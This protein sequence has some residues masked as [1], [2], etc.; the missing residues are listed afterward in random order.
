MQDEFDVIVNRRKQ[1]VSP[2]TANDEDEF[3][4]I[5]QRRAPTPAERPPLW[6]RIKDVG[7]GIAAD[8]IGAAKGIGKGLAT[9]ALDLVHLSQGD[10][11]YMTQEIANEF[12]KGPGAEGRLIARGVGAASMLVPTMRVGGVV[13]SA[14]VNMAAN[15]GLGA[16]QTPED[17]MLGAILGAGVPLAGKAVGRVTGATA[18]A[19]LGKFRP[20]INLEGVTD[21]IAR[22]LDDAQRNTIP[23]RRVSKT[24]RAT[25]S[26]DDIGGVESVNKILAERTPRQLEGLDAA[27]VQPRP[28]PLVPAA[29]TPISGT[30]LAEL[31]GPRREVVA[32][33]TGK[34]ALVD[35]E[36]RADRV[37]G[38]RLDAAEQRALEK[39]MVKEVKEIDKANAETAVGML[40]RANAEFNKSTRAKNA[41]R[42]ALA[43]R[44]GVQVEP[45]AVD[46]PVT[47]AI[48]QSV[49]EPTPVA[50]VAAQGILEPLATPVA[51]PVGVV[52]PPPVAPSASSLPAADA[53]YLNWRTLGVDP[54]KPDALNM[55]AAARVQAAATRP[56][57]VER[58][59]KERGRTT[60]DAMNAEAQQSWAIRQLGID[61][62]AVD[63]EKLRGLSGAQ[64]HALK[65][66]LMENAA[67]MESIARELPDLSGDDLAKAT[68]V[69][70]RLE[71]SNDELLATI[72]REGS[73]RGRDLGALRQLA[74][75][76][77]D[78]AVWLLK[79]KKVLGDTPM[80]ASVQAKI[81]RL[82]KEA[83]EACGG[84]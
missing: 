60:F 79:A 1:P 31:D 2:P 6:E 72:Q 20:D 40:G 29:D 75:M 15:A 45:S 76:T 13:T 14:L 71:K 56:D 80:T 70:E 5:V 73:A 23:K 30:Y 3:D 47:P 81:M 57:M 42:A 49:P 36:V 61:P 25:V 4:A 11:P 12:A 10:V 17:P 50:D 59:A 34:K 82:A 24:Q 65:A 27:T 58:L 54:A 84:A 41:A 9:N 62:L 64:I 68:T 55:S 66:P 18:R 37:A 43:R 67:L 22:G 63:S 46:A 8:P 51:P 44:R 16:A 19:A 35:P 74:N 32:T 48:S 28:N 26:L 21:D 69:F 33:P 52:E 78:P 7:R 83:A 77:T 39:Q 53:P 38:E